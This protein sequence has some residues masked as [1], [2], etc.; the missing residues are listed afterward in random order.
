YGFRDREIPIEKPP[1]TYRILILGDSFTF[2]IGNNLQDTFA[3]QLEKRLNEREEG[4]KFEVINGGCSSYS[5]ILEYLL[6]AQKGLA[7]NPDLV[8]LNY[9]LSDVQDDYKYSQIAEFDG[10][11]R[12]TKVHPIDVQ[13]YY[14]E[15]KTGYQ[16]GFALLDHSE[17]Y[18]F[19]I[20][21]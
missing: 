2:G 7:L 18:Q 12:P 1:G 13:W 8:I 20:K 16:S 19:I 3:K 5:P 10:E 14:R 17:L 15:L 9:D 4:M 11:G 21:R 6:L